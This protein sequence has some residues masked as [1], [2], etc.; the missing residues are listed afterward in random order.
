MEKMVSWSRGGLGRRSPFPEAQYH[1]TAS[2]AP[3]QALLSTHRTPEEWGKGVYVPDHPDTHE[4]QPDIN[5]E[6]C[7]QK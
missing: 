7:S 2:C 3:T 4:F 5:L 6:S 1:G